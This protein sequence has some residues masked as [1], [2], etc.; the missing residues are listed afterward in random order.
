MSCKDGVVDLLGID[1]SFLGELLDLE[2]E[3]S[4]LVITL[5]EVLTSVTVLGN[6]L[7]IEQG[8]LAERTFAE[9][10]IPVGF[11]LIGRIINPLATYLDN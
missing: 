11:F 1:L 10:L 7:S 6:D 4:A 9:L 2:G 3:V 8:D 5:N